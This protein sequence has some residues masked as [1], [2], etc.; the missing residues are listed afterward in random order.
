MRRLG[1]KEGEMGRLGPFSEDFSFYFERKREQN[2]EN[3]FNVG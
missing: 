2:G 3:G 1:D